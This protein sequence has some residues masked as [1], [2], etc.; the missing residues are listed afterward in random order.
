MRTEFRM[1]F[2]LALLV[3]FAIIFSQDRLN[4][5]LVVIFQYYAI[6][7]AKTKL[8]FVVYFSGAFLSSLSSIYLLQKWSTQLNFL[9]GLFLAFLG[10]L[11]VCLSSHFYVFLISRGIEGF[12]IQLSAS[13]I[14]AAIAM[15]FNGKNPV[16]IHKK[17]T[18]YPTSAQVFSI[19][20]TVMT[21]SGITVPALAGLI[22]SLYGWLSLYY[23]FILLIVA[24]FLVSVSFKWSFVKDLP[25][26]EHLFMKEK[27]RKI[28]GHER[29]L[30]NAII[31]SLLTVLII[32]QIISFSLLFLDNLKMHPGH[33]GL[34][35]FFLGGSSLISSYLCL[36]YAKAHEELLRKIAFCSLIFFL[37]LML[38]LNLK[39]LN[40][41]TFVFPLA[42]ASISL[43]TLVPLMAAQSFASY[44]MNPKLASSF[45]NSF[46]MIA[47]ICG[48]I[49]ASLIET[50]RFQVVFGV[51]ILLS[52]IVAGLYFF[53]LKY[54]KTGIL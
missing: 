22:G 46:Q 13:V 38:L 20:S 5:M 40:L 53:V 47:C 17:L 50:T 4:P 27:L 11:A 8:S 44:K 10:A 9:L 3:S 19:G 49:L 41:L 18:L 52:I 29:F 23:A 42:G 7:L 1:L 35:S 24:V 12:G 51:A 37:V 33:F 25:K 28:L 54:H 2:L 16:T 31:A 45:Y 6:S 15:A 32:Y 34:L 36:R 48:A 26:K 43:E 39:H 30:I 14:T 21:W